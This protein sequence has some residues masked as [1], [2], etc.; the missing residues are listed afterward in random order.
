MVTAEDQ[1]AVNIK[2]PRVR[3]EAD[4]RRILGVSYALK[5]ICIDLC[6]PDGWG[7]S[8]GGRNER[9]MLADT[10]TA[11][12][13]QRLR[14]SSVVCTLFSGRN[15]RERVEEGGNSGAGGGRDL[16]PTGAAKQV[17]TPTALA[18]T[19][20]SWLWVPFWG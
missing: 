6:C 8:G 7:A 11:A 20:R 5:V 10:S 1:T 13:K 15:A 2:A 3:L 4:S 12:K 19:N 18:H 9:V 17:A 14:I 16:P